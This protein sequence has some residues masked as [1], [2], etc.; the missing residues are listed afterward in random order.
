MAECPLC[1]KGIVHLTVEIH[2][3]CDDLGLESGPCDIKCPT[4]DG[5]NEMSQNDR[6]M[7]L[8]L[9]EEVE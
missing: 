8:T 3:S 6:E 9:K 2:P 5:T 4:C 1:D 7:W